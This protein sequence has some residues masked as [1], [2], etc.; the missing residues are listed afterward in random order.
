ME[1]EA[2]AVVLLLASGGL[3]CLGCPL[4]VLGSLIPQSH[5]VFP[6][7]ITLGITSCL[8]GHVALPS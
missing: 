3:L 6:D 4:V 8:C 7:A 2:L 5:P 1:L